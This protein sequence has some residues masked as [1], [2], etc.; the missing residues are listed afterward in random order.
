MQRKCQG[1]TLTWKRNICLPCHAVFTLGRAM[2]Y[3]MQVGNEVCL[4]VLHSSPVPLSHLPPL[5]PHQHLSD[6]YQF[7]HFPAVFV[8][9]SSP[10]SSGNSLCIKSF[11]R[12][13]TLLRGSDFRA[14]FAMALALACCIGELQVA[15]LMWQAAETERKL[16]CFTALSWPTISN[17]LRPVGRKPEL[18]FTN[19][20]Y[21]SARTQLSQADQTSAHV[22]SS[23][24]VFLSLRP[25]LTASHLDVD[26]WQI[27]NATYDEYRTRTGD[28]RTRITSI[29]V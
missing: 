7:W 6:K 5:P 18:A 26:A 24:I 27:S 19:Q 11:C 16:S 22:P 9:D 1:H 17:S 28:W 3:V 15:V 21:L 4:Y 14:G 12:W 25:Q 23:D 29:S 10:A 2:A 20:P 8:S 13:V